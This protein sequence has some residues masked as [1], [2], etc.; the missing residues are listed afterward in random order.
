MKKRREREEVCARGK[1]RNERE[2]LNM[3]RQGNLEITF[4]LRTAQ[5]KIQGKGG[6]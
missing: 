2:E 6:K 1:E 4:S 3:S 5:I